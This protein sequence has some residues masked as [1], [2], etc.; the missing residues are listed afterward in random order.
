MSECDISL[1]DEFL[2]RFMNAYRAIRVKVATGAGSHVNCRDVVIDGVS[3]RRLGEAAR[4]HLV[5]KTIRFHIG[6]GIED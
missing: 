4:I 2:A 3:I 1:E 5:L 6:K